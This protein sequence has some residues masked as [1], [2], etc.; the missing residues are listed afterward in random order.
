MART[1]AVRDREASRKRRRGKSG[2]VEKND[3]SNNGSS[4]STSS[5]APS[6]D[7]FNRRSVDSK[8]VD[9]SVAGSTA[10]PGYSEDTE[11]GSSAKQSPKIVILCPPCT[12]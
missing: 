2:D 10:S 1:Q 11:K 12:W 5:K 3:G 6:T 9:T 4:G 8:S 7:G